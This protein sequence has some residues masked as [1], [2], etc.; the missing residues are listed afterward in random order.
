M[1]VVILRDRRLLRSSARRAGGILR[2]PCHQEIK[3]FPVVGGNIHFHI[4]LGLFQCDILIPIG[5]AELVHGPAA[6]E[7]FS[8][9][10]PDTEGRTEAVLAL[11]DHRVPALC[12]GIADRVMGSDTDRSAAGGIAE[13]G[14]K[15]GIARSAR[16]RSPS[17]VD[18]IAARCSF[19][20]QILYWRFPISTFSRRE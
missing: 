7:A 3:P 8:S 17:S 20:P 13:T 2:L 14:V 4:Q 18:P 1:V 11:V 19:R 5:K 12:L 6:C 9:A 10:R 15:I 16:A